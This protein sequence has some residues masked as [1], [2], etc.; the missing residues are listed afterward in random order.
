M[1]VDKPVISILDTTSLPKR[2]TDYEAE[3][4]ELA[5][6]AQA[7]NQ[8]PYLYQQNRSFFRN[9]LAG[10]TENV[11]AFDADEMVGYAAL[12]SMDPWP[13]YMPQTE[14]EPHLC[15]MMLYS[16]VAPKYRGRAIGFSLAQ[17]RVTL[18]KELGFM[19]LY[20]TVHPNNLASARTLKRLGFEVLSQKV[21]FTE[22]LLRDIL[23]LRIVN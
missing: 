16:L 8:S 19:H 2:A 11:F 1:S 12:R 10:A 23:Y 4:V 22:Q 9:N 20:A 3:L 5:L 7:D 15:A 14:H 13:A 17:K 21:M 6:L 18:A